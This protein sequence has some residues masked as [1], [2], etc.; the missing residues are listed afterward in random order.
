MDAD[1]LFNDSHLLFRASC[2]VAAKNYKL[3]QSQFS[4][5]PTNLHADLQYQVVY[6]VC[7]VL[8][9]SYISK[10]VTLQKCFSCIDKKI[11]Y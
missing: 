3:L 11:T 4:I 9:T 7:C 8:F 2:K 1:F 5:L 10:L 6:M